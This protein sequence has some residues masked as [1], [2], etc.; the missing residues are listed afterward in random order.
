MT[1]S[2]QIPHF[3]YDDEY[4]MSKLVR[5]R[6][7]FKYESKRMVGNK[8]SF[9]P[10]ILKGCSMALSEYPILNSHIDVQNESII[11]KV[12][13]IGLSNSII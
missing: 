4:D 8:I 13:I 9:M 2:L 10:F 11:F 6:E 3:G 12:N 7:Q 5:V 1:A